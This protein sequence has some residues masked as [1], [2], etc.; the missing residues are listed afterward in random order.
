MNVYNAFLSF[1]RRDYRFPELEG[2]SAAT[3]AYRATV[4]VVASGA[5]DGCESDEDLDT[6]IAL[7]VE[8]IERG[9]LTQAHLNAAIDFCDERIANFT[10][11]EVGSDFVRNS[12][13]FRHSL[14]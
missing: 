10:D 3:W 11:S 7:A 6:A 9:E 1:L 8:K 14:N 5:L 13:L 4:A 2:D 12:H